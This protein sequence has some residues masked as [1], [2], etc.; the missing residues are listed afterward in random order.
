[1]A[2]IGS[3]PVSSPDAPLQLSSPVIAPVCKL[4]HDLVVSALQAGIFQQ[5]QRNVGGVAQ[6]RLLVEDLRDDVLRSGEVLTERMRDA[7]SRRL[8]LTARSCRPPIWGLGGVGTSVD[9]LSVLRTV[10]TYRNRGELGGIYRA[11]PRILLL[12][13]LNHL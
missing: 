4:I 9:L 13:K 8:L 5:R 10:R 2:N 3:G 6:H 1:V 12:N 11:D 7:G